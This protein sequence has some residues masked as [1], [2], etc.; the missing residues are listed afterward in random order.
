MGCEE[1]RAGEVNN[2]ESARQARHA[3]PRT[4]SSTISAAVRPAASA[5]KLITRRWVKHR[6]RHA[7]VLGTR[8]RRHDV[9]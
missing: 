1:P 6:G 2:S 3:A 9:S 5:A 7:P 4:N 8:C